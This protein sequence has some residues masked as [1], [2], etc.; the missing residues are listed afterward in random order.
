MVDESIQIKLL[1]RFNP[2][3]ALLRLHQLRMLKILKYFDRI[4]KEN[5]IPYWLSSGTCL[6]AVRHGGFIPW[7]YMTLPDIS[8]IKPKHTI[9]LEL[10]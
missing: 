4:C 1:E 5:Y 8:K 6:S 9:R 7:D 10:F 2:D 3:G